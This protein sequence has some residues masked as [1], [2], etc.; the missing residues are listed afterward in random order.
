MESE[1]NL[2][3]VFGGVIQLMLAVVCFCSLAIKRLT[4]RPVRTW[5]IFILVICNQDTSK[6]AFSALVAHVM[7]M[8]ASLVLSQ[9]EEGN[10]CL[11][12]FITL[13]MDTT[14]GVVIAYILLKI[15]EKVSRNNG[16]TK[17]ISGNY[18]E[19]TDEEIDFAAWSLQLMIWVSIVAFVKWML[20]IAIIYFHLFFVRVGKM[21]L[22]PFADNPKFELVFVMIIV[23]AFMNI[24]QFWVQ[25][26]FLK[27]KE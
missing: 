16:W 26:N 10:P 18:S 14:F 7:N 22:E 11:W 6:Q 20:L 19:D 13:M 4:E 24:L 27:Q 23:P 25:D 21:M 1:C 17:A 3:G 2:F 5:P 15:I 8:M 12:Y 9:R